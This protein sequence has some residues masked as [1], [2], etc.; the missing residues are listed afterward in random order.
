MRTL[1]RLTWGVSESGA[2]TCPC[3]Q[4]V[5]LQG[6]SLSTERHS[7]SL[8]TSPWARYGESDDG[9]LEQLLQ[10]RLRQ[11]MGS[12]ASPANVL[13]ESQTRSNA[14][15]RLS[16]ARAVMC[17]VTN[18]PAEID[19]THACIHY[20]AE[21]WGSSDFHCL[22]QTKVHALTHVR[23]IADIDRDE[24]DGPR[25]VWPTHPSDERTDR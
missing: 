16:G 22:S 5:S 7:P 17:C 8:P 3:R 11:E 1:H 10:G 25:H 24:S 9:V 14:R 20:D 13:K 4:L 2:H 12:Q 23:S 21:P 18:T 6:F 15:P 19:K